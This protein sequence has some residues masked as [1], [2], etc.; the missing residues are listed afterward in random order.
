MSEELLAAMKKSRQCKPLYALE[1][2]FSD[3]TE[4]SSERLFHPCY[5]FEKD[6]EAS[7]SGACRSCGHSC[8]FISLRLQIHGCLT[9]GDTF[10]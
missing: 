4:L 6:C 10:I 3:S 9:E 7:A 5:V 1:G 8:D 2:F